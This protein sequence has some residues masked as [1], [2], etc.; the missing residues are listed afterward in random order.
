MKPIKPPYSRKQQM[1]KEHR[2]YYANLF[3]TH[4]G[5]RPKELIDVFGLCE[6]SIFRWHTKLINAGYDIPSLPPKPIVRNGVVVKRKTINVKYVEKNPTKLNA[7]KKHKLDEPTPTKVKDFS[8]G[9]KYVKIDS[10]TY[11]QVKIA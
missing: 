6:N 3:I 7:G 10:R 1:V 9:Y 8:T 4:A 11:K 5:K 2:D